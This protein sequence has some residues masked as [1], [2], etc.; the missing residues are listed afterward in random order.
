MSESSR[1]GIVGGWKDCSTYAENLFLAI[2][3]GRG[4]CPAGRPLVPGLRRRGPAACSA[5]VVRAR[6]ALAGD[7]GGELADAQWFGDLVID[8]FYRNRPMGISETIRVEAQL[9][10]LV[11]DVRS[12]GTTGAT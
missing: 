12:S 6:Q 8:D 2:P 11:E 9:F 10:Q 4:R 1:G 3:E 5:I 7:Q